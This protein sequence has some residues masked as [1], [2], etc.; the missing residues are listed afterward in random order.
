MFAAR[1]VDGATTV[2]VVN[3]NLNSPCELKLDV[4]HLKGAMRV[5]RFDQ[6]TGDKVVEIAD[7]AGPVDGAIRRT[8]PAASASIL[9]I[10]PARSE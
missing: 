7:Q 6:E 10:A 1:R 2:V 4:G 5:W 9:V 3:K 8:M